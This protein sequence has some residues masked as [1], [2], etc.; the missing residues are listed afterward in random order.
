MSNPF[1]KAAISRVRK[2]VA[3]IL[4]SCL[5]LSTLTFSS[6]V[7]TVSALAPSLKTESQIKSEAALY[8][9]AIR[10]INHLANINLASLD[11]VK[12][13]RATLE[14]NVPNLRFNRSKLV[15]IAMNDSSFIGAARAKSN[16]P[17]AAREFIEAFCKDSK[18]ILNLPGAASVASRMQSSLDADNSMLQKIAD[19]LK[20]GSAELKKGNAHHAVKTVPAFAPTPAVSATLIETLVLAAAVVVFP[21]LA[22]V[23]F[24]VAA[25]G[26]IVA[27]AALVVGRLVV[28]IGTEKGRDAVAAC[29]DQAEANYRSCAEKAQ[30]LGPLLGPIAVE[31]CLAVWLAE[32]GGCLLTDSN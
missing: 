6:S 14:K 24:E 23:L 19:L 17:K 30:G 4:F 20:K 5:F 16:D 22:I 27:V 15:S 11:N 31:A 1:A 7:R 12:V 9:T 3:L 25:N 21:P 2:L 13:A 26:A 8:D 32:A 29:E 10:E 18:S 28:N